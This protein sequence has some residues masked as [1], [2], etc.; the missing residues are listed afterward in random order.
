[1]KKL[2][3]VAD[4]NLFIIGWLSSSLYIS[5]VNY[6]DMIGGCT[7]NEKKV[8]WKALIR[9]I[10]M[11]NFLWWKKLRQ[12]IYNAEYVAALVSQPFQPHSG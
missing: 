3:I 1:M 10:V 8:C 12:K 11:S 4:N 5:D 2:N 6:T 9:V 7:K